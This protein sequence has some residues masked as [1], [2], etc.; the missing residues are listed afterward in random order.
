MYPSFRVVVALFIK[1]KVSINNIGAS[2]S[3][4][5]FWT[6]CRGFWYAFLFNMPICPLK[7]PPPLSKAQKLSNSLEINWQF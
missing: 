4:E 5:L 6:L 7:N 2:W 3:P 1:P